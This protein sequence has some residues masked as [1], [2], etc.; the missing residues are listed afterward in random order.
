MQ[1]LDS[2]VDLLNLSSFSDPLAD[3]LTNQL[4]AQGAQRQVHQM[5]LL[6]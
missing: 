4:A 1:E 5:Y 2:G 6:G 3:G